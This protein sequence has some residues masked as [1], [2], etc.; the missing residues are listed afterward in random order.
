MCL[1][2]SIAG[3]CGWVSVLIYRPVKLGWRVGQDG[4]QFDIL[5]YIMKGIPK[6]GEAVFQTVEAAAAVVPEPQEAKEE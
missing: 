4:Y 3:G 5:S 6:K 2:D 1:T